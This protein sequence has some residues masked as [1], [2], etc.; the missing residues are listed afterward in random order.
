MERR[1][2]FFQTSICKILFPY[3][4]ELARRGSYKEAEESLKFILSYDSSPEYLLLLGKIYAQQGRYKDAID[5]WKRVL[6]LDPENQE[7]RAAILK[8]ERLRENVL[9]SQFFKWKL[10][11][12]VLCLILMLTLGINLTLWRGKLYIFSQYKDSLENNQALS[13]K[14]EELEKQFKELKKEIDISKKRYKKLVKYQLTQIKG[15]RSSKI[16]IKQQDGHISIYGEVPTDYLKELI[17]K[18]IRR[19]EGV[20]TVDTQGLKVT[21]TYTISSGDVLSKIAE[22]LYGDHKKWVKI[23]KMNQDKI[24]NPDIIYPGDSLDMP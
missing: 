19:L 4:V 18:V 17:E 3:T 10:I 2:D 16:T 5:V 20:K 8:A 6:V 9:P 22:E 15:L 24:K 14:Y 13:V 12:C 21:H 23:F 7:A 1:T 11:V